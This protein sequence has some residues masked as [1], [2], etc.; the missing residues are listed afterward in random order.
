MSIKIKTPRRRTVPIICILIMLLVPTQVQSQ[1]STDTFD[2]SIKI[3]EER[4][5]VKRGET[6]ELTV[7]VILLEGLAQNIELDC[8]IIEIMD[9]KE[10]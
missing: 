9:Y 5:S 1:E 2:F 6:A 10:S 3:T 4:V 7:D 8:R